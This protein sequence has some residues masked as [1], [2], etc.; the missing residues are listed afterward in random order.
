M[1]FFVY[2]P[3]TNENLDFLV[4]DHKVKGVW[5][6]IF[7]FLFFPKSV[8]PNVQNILLELFGFFTKIREY[9]RIL[10]LVAIGL[11]YTLIEFIF[12]KTFIRV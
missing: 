6:E 10:E 7:S 8:S 11:Q 12:K 9:I 5:R 2:N 1:F 4:A 3:M